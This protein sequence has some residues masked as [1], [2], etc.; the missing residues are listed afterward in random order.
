[1]YSVCAHSYPVSLTTDHDTFVGSMTI[2]VRTLPM[3]GDGVLIDKGA[4]D[5]KWGLIE[6]LDMRCQ[7]VSHWRVSVR[8]F[9]L[10]VQVHQSSIDP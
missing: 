4:C 10:R 5:R 8:T 2:N 6:P 3:S 1:M 7:S 9:R